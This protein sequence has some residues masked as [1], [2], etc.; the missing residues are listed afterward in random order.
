MPSFISIEPTNCCN[1]F[2]PECNS[3]KVSYN[4]QQGYMELALF[5]N[6]ISELSPY[7]TYLNLYN[8]GEPLLH[9]D[10]FELIKFASSKKIFTCLSTNAQ[11]LDDNRAREIVESGLGKIIISID[12]I[13]QES[14]SSYR[15]GGELNKVISG[16]QNILKWRKMLNKTSPYIV[17]Q[18][19]VFKT[20]E[21]EIKK[22]SE[23]GKKLKVDQTEFKTAQINNYK[24]NNDLIPQNS[25]YSRYYKG[26]DNTFFLKNKLKNKC[27][28][29]WSSAVITFNGAVSP[30]CFD[31]NAEYIMGNLSN[32][33][34]KTI[35]FNDVYNYFRKSVFISRKNID[36]CTN[37]SEGLCI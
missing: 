27:W 34:F 25:R 4:K 29:M 31:K 16:A 10:I 12:G 33:C 14:Y 1:L 23:L 24:T 22:I 19:I 15:I 30:C 6:I 5:K 32:S 7:L 37:C 26:N 11:L 20:N 17:F 21:H 13:S 36:I 35:W 3:V 28:R 9:H 8:Q 2:C 18:F